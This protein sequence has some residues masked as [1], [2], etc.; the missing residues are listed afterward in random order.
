[1]GVTLIIVATLAAVVGI[2]LLVDGAIPAPN[3]P[4]SHPGRRASWSKDHAT[5]LALVGS[6]VAAVVLVTT[7]WVLPAVVAAIAGMWLAGSWLS[8]H[9]GDHLELVRV[10][11]LATWTEQLRDVMLGGDQVIGAITAT[12]ST[13]PQVIQPPVRALAARL[14]RQP[15]DIVLRRFADELD[16]PTADLVAAGLL[17][18]LTRGGRTEQILTSL[19]EQARHHAERRRLV[20]AERAP[21]RKEVVWVSTI[22]GVFL[23]G[24]LLFSRT[25][26]LAP[27]GTLHGQ[28][29]LSVMLALYASLLVWVQRLARFPRPARFLTL[30]GG[31]P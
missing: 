7:Q 15:A 29:A 27:Y 3:V 20:E 22:M 18:A 10:E 30:D 28:V 8:H 4:T 24:L 6:G 14:G 1:M 17:V 21:A 9:R 23:L 31:E 11:A 12:A 2:V 19:A 13:C 5:P 16:D 26:Y 25:R